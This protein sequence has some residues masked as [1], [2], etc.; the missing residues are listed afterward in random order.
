[1]STT[2]VQAAAKPVLI[3]TIEQRRADA[4]RNALA[5]AYAVAQANRFTS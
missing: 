2:Q 3:N 4:V 1:M 5:L